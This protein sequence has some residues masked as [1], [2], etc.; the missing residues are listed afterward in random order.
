MS[1]DLC[2]RHVTVYF[3]LDL[4]RKTCASRVLAFPSTIKMVANDQAYTALQQYLQNTFNPA[5]A[6]QKEAERQLFAFEV[7]PGFSIVLLRLISD[8]QVDV[9]L[10]FAASLYF[11]NFVKRQ[12]VPE[13]DDINNI[14]PEDRVAIKTQIVQLMISVPEKLQ[15]QLSDA[16]SIMAETDFPEEWTNLLPELISQLSPTD[17]KTNN[18]ILHT[19][20]SIFKRWRSQFKSDTLF[21]KIKYVLDVFCEPYMQLFQ[22]TDRLMTENANNEHALQILAQSIILLIKIFYDLN[23]QD[24]PEFFEDN[25]ATFMAL[26][27]KY[28]LYNNPLLVSEDE[29]E[30]GPLEKIKT[31]ICEIVELY[32][33]KYSEEFEQLKDFIPIVFELLA[34]TGQESKYDTMVGNGLATLTCIIRLRKYSDIF[35][36]ETTMQQMCEKI[37]LPNISM[38]TS[39]EELFED[40]PIE[41]IRRDIEGS[42]SDT[43]RRA[44][45]D[46]IRGIME[47]F[48]P[49]V[50]SIMSRYIN[51][52]L[53]RYAANPTKNWRDKNTAIFLLIAIATRNAT[54]QVGVLNT[55]SHVDVVDFFTKNVLGDLQ[56]DVNA[57]IPFLK[58]D[59]IKYLYT[60]RNQL[61][62]D[63]L[64]TVFPL[65]VNH[66]QSTDYVVH[67]YAAIAIE[68]ILFIRQGK[69]MLF[70]AEDIKLYAETLLSELSRLIELG[71]TPEKLSENDYLMKAVMRVIITSRQDMV[72]YVNV[73]M[74][75]LT[76]ILA[77]VSKNPS[78]PRFNHYIFESIGALIRFICPISPQAVDEFETMLFT[79]F[80]TILTQ[81]VQEF[82]PYVFQLLAQLL[83]NHS[84]QDLPQLYI[85]WLTPLLN[86]TLWEQGNIPALVRLLEA[87]LSRGVNTIISQN[88][89]EPI[90]GIFQQKLVNS[91]QNDHYGISLLTALTKHVPMS[92]FGK[93]LPT[94]VASVLKRLQIK[95][96]KEGMVFDRFTRNFTLWFCLFCTLD[97]TG[98]PDT[99]ISVFESLQP[100]L[101]GQI[102]TIFV[103]PD[104]P[105][106]RDPVDKKICGVGLVRLLTQSDAMLQEPYVSGL[107]TNV[108]L[109]LVD[110]LE[111]APEIAEDGPDELYTLDLE[112]EGGYQTSFTKLAT[113]NPVRDDPV[114]G[115]PACPIFLA[116]K[117]VAM[118]PERREIVKQ[119]MAKTEEANKYLPK[120]FESAGISMAQL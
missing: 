49:Q 119:L 15:L 3:L 109:N 111:L 32:T 76:G 105:I 116:Q 67:T 57:G 17:Y 66:L 63:Q 98:G 54:T 4:T 33:Q 36:Q 24:L 42:D 21:A 34:N 95:K 5:A 89:L 11:K 94:L 112:E 28:L 102:I 25:I 13:S 92:I 18:G 37:A 59:A 16:L 84:G 80:Q 44:A 75:K 118:T 20:H 65:L 93:Y 26:F 61:T 96:T 79:P 108:F 6:V 113:S 51:S 2:S 81:G 90:L 68:R 86:P 91:R 41:Y 45:A 87:Y 115:F 110:Q 117:L 69:T 97:S 88:K 27:Q 85:D 120:Y 40:N 106:V 10:R 104:L 53:E 73:I 107:W 23:C 103:I 22:I 52:Y 58:V 8:Q 55:N 7:Q 60:F 64:L 39:D 43:R 38:R 48:E 100:G 99:L 1:G 72:Q 114:A 83:E 47:L 31:G 101:F 74:G 35:G 77:V 56:T 46:F 62:K 19:A 14:T 82:M 29:E 71:Q 30:A 70:T 78:N 12:W 50:T 9:T